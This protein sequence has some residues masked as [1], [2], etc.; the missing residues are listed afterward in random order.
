[1]KKLL[2]MLIVAFIIA[3]IV[4]IVAIVLPSYEKHQEMTRKL[5]NAESEL[6]KQKNECLTLKQKLNTI[7]HSTTEIER[8]A[9]EKFNYCKSDELIYKFNGKR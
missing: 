7:K 6:T 5:N 3:I 1:M 9:R 4:A 8:I 2:T